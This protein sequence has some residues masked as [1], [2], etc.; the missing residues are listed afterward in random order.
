MRRV[1]YKRDVIRE[2]KTWRMQAVLL[3]RKELRILFVE[4]AQSQLPED[5][6]MGAISE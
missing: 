1:S 4:P 3:G 2:K 6:A 5:G